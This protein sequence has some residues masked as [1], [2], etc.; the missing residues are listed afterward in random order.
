MDS[1]FVIILIIQICKLALLS[2]EVIGAEKYF[3]VIKDPVIVEELAVSAA[4]M[5]SRTDLGKSEPKSCIC[6]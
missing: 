4:Q 3:E 5:E 6:I 1:N 2:I